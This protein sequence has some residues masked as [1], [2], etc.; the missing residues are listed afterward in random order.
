M[1]FLNAIVQD[2]HY[3]TSSC[4]AL[5]PCYFGIQVLCRGG[6]EETMLLFSCQSS[7]TD[8]SKTNQEKGFIRV[9]T[10]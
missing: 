1:V 9:R 10:V 7:V 8:T 5:S 2:S 6:L 4:V 3:Y